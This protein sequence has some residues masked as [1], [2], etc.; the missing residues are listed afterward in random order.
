MCSRRDSRAALLCWPPLGLAALGLLLP[1]RLPPQHV[2][3]YKLGQ[4]AVEVGR[5]LIRHHVSHA[6]QR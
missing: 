2:L 5:R 6:L 3:Q 4:Q 1:P